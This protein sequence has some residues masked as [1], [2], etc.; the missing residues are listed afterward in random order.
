MRLSPVV[1]RWV[2]FTVMY[3]LEFTEMTSMLYFI[4]FLQNPEMIRKSETRESQTTI[5]SLHK[6]VHNISARSE[7]C[8]MPFNVDECHILY[9][10]EPTPCW[11]AGGIILLDHGSSVCVCV[12]V[13]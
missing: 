1:S 4:T 8:E 12:C 9:G 10:F 3:Y 7:R 5:G 13:C 2:K 6:N 11:M